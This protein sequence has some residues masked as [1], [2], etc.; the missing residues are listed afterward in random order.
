MDKHDIEVSFSSEI[1]YSPTE[2]KLGDSLNSSY[3]EKNISK[4]SL[5]INSCIEEM[6]PLGNSLMDESWEYSSGIPNNSNIKT[7]NF[8]VLS[9][10]P[11]KAKTNVYEFTS[12]IESLPSPIQINKRKHR[13]FNTA[14]L[15]LNL[16]ETSPIHDNNVTSSYDVSS[17]EEVID[18]DSIGTLRCKDD[19]GNIEFCKCLWF[20]Y[21]LMI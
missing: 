9:S 2:V 18:L 5:D 21:L 3:R 12:D 10:T 13:S 1:S 16:T 6:T 14:T 4:D 15:E 19:T 7:N 8:S 20:S 11:V 17:S